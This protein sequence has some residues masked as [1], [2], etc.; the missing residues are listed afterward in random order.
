MI[1][2][3]GQ[4]CLMAVFGM[5]VAPV[6]AQQPAA[7]SSEDERLKATR[8]LWPVEDMMQRAC[9]GISAHYKLDD[10]QKDF[11]CKLLTERV[12]KFLDSY[13][14]DLWPVLADLT[15][16]QYSG[17]K[18]DAETA[19]RIAARGYP[20]F[21]EAQ[22]EIMKAQDEF[23][24]ILS[25][26]QKKIH[27]QDLKQLKRTFETM[28]GTFRNW[29]EGKVQSPAGINVALPGQQNLLGGPGQQAGRSRA[30]SPE[31]LWEKYVR[32]FIAKYQLDEKQKTAA[33][34]VLKDL[35]DQ[36]ER[37]RTANTKEL[38][39]SE[40][41]VQEVQSAK[42]VDL[43]ALEQA[44]MIRD[45]YYKPFNDWFEELKSRL[46]LIPTAQQ[47]ENYE[48][49]AATAKSLTSRPTTPP[50]ASQPQVETPPPATQPAN[51][52]APTPAPNP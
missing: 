26:D 14:K 10:K 18:P 49:R 7:N 47:K 43:K 5:M 17:D 44:K 12:T 16:F 48:K 22:K 51:V 19:K 24:Q 28:D 21:L 4:W 40:A 8:S 1:Q 34:A 46:D 41:Y 13:D 29:R 32:E 38:A 3:Y 39:E 6:V 30:S 20:V 37:Y 25:D 27:D 50:P 15:P 11:T 9:D 35:K 31:A 36:A 42:P 2:R 23:R 52:P 33:L 45:L